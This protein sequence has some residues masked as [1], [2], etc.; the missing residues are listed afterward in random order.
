MPA[1]AA[2]SS[3]ALHRMLAG[4]VREHWRAYA[5]AGGMLS[6]IALLTVWIPRQVGHVVDALVAGH[7]QGAALLR[8]LGLLVAAGLVIYLL[9]AG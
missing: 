3:S 1:S 7:L 4:F 2:S 6:C 5:A 8:Q 9:R